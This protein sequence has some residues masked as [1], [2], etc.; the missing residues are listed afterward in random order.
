MCC[1][2]FIFSSGV[3]L[4]I[5]LGKFSIYYLIEVFVVFTKHYMKVFW[6]CMPMMST[7]LSYYLGHIGIVFINYLPLKMVNPIMPFIGV[8]VILITSHDSIFIIH[9]NGT[10]S[11]ATANG[12]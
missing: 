9:G 6:G 7:C 8:F 2:L 4:I 3:I 11:S 1:L 5:A 10:K 12:T